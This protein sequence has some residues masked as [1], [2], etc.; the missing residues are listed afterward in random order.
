MEKLVRFPKTFL[1]YAPPAVTVEM[2]A[3]PVH[4]NGYITFASFN[5]FAKLSPLTIRL[6]SRILAS[7]PNSRLLIKTQGL[8]DPGLRA[9]LLERFLDQG[10]DRDRI[11]LMPPIL[12]QR[13]HL[14][15]YSEVDVALDPFPYHG[16]TTTLEAIWMGVPVVTLEGDR[17]AARVGASILSCLGLDELVAHNED[18]YVRIATRLAGPNSPLDVLRQS[19]RSRLSESPLTDGARFT[20]DLEQAYFKMREDMLTRCATSMPTYSIDGYG[21]GIGKALQ[22]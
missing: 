16:T 1:C 13:E 17:H 4:R 10:V 7:S 12:D 9:L 20:A 3:A 19:L 14:Q 22:D 5:N 18:E 15:T 21:T 11:K 6:W 8:Q 2:T